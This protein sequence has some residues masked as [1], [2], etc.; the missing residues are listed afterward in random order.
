MPDAVS[1]TLP[2]L[3]VEAVLRV[4]E[5]INDIKKTVMQRMRKIARGGV[6]AGARI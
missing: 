2:S 6:P 1:G 5:L 4:E 3:L